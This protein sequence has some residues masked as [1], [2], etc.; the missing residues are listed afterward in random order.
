MTP[1]L[2]SGGAAGAVPQGWRPI[3]TA[4]RDG[5]NILLRFGLDCVSQGCY[6]PGW[7][8]PWRFIDTNDGISWLVNHAIDGL[9]GPSH[10]QPL[11]SA[12]M[13]AAG[14]GRG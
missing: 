4:P 12:E 10:W 13:P 14:G 7:P 8:R 1:G 5:T 2:D 11:A 6:V 9:G 3:A